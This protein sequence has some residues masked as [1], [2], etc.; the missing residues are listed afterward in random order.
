[1][2]NMYRDGESMMRH[3]DGISWATIYRS[4]NNVAKG[5]AERHRLDEVQR[6]YVWALWATRSRF[7]DTEVPDGYIDLVQ[8]KLRAAIEAG[9]GRSGG[10]DL[11]EEVTTLFPFEFGS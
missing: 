5:L 1:M 10:P 9:R 4:A 6:E 2:G 11:P 7:R 8:P 3:L